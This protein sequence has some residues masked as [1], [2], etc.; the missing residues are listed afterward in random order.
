[1]DS[2]ASAVGLRRHASCCQPPDC[3]HCSDCPSMASQEL[4][5][6]MG[7]AGLRQM[8]NKRVME[9]V[10][11]CSA[12]VSCESGNPWSPVT[13]VIPA[14]KQGSWSSALPHS[15][16]APTRDLL[17]QHSVCSVQR[18]CLIFPQKKG[19]SSL[20]FSVCQ[21]KK[22]YMRGYLVNHYWFKPWGGLFDIKK[23]KLKTI[24][25]Q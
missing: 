17:T 6:H 13:T 5:M 22:I 18:F 7:L 20:C 15:L 12:E 8:K 14:I 3:S 16:R 19:K 9:H 1:M 25:Q 23:K 21:K 11:N 2:W 10:L 4:W 24:M